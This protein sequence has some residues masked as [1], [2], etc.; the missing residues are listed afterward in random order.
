MPAK[1][2]KEKPLTEFGLWL[3]RHD[4]SAERAA[5]KLGC[6]RQTVYLLSVGETAARLDIAKEIEDWTRAVSPGDYISMQALAREVH[7]QR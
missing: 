4:F 5:E 6:S 3:N 2:R 1:K 7:S